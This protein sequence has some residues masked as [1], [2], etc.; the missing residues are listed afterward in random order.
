MEAAR[1]R[2]RRRRTRRGTVDSPLNVRLVRVASLLVVPALLAM[3]FSISTTGTL[4]R[5]ALAPL[6]DA[7]AAATLATQLQTEYPSRIP[8][9]PGDAGAARWF[10]E[11]ISASGFATR[12]DV[13]RESVPGLGDVVLRNVITTIPGRSAQAVILVAHR[14]NQGAGAPFGENASGTAALIELARGYAPQEASAAAQ[15]QRTVILVSTDA[16]AY[17]GAGAYRFVGRSQAARDAFAAVILDGI[18][19]RG[20]PQVLVA[21]DGATSPAPALVSTAVARVREQVGTTPEL[22]SAATQL[23]DLGIPYAA[24]EQGP[25]LGAGTAAVTL[26]TDRHGDAVGISTTRLG[27]LG[28]ATET[29]LG[30]IDAS[31]GRAFGTHDSLF[32]RGRKASGWTVRLALVVAVVPFALGVL[33]LVV[34]VR[35]RGLRIAP[36]ARSLRARVLF[37]LYA[38]LL[39]G[40]GAVLGV[41]PTGAA[42]PLPPTSPA[43]GGRPVAGLALLGIALLLGWLVG[44]RRLIVS[45]RATPEDRL[46]GYAVALAWLAA[47][48]VVTA[49][50]HPYTLLFV[51]PSLY[52]WLWL[53]LRTRIWARALVYGAGFAGLAFALVVLSREIGLSLPATA[54]YAA[55][56]V[57]VG[58]IPVS[59]ALL[60][61][62][63]LAAAAQ[64]AAL[65]F[66]RYTPYAG[67][68][69]PPPPSVVR[70]SV[71]AVVRR[72]RARA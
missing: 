48:A 61:I 69:E 42:L 14:D 60:V 20:S 3:L 2:G 18:A 39:L 41:F 65:A 38:G 40:I 33:D 51:L 29:L 68:T 4:P 44:R 71:G 23:V 5:P 12:E 52:T 17:G 70:E 53:P 45:S 28:S 37:W 36:A 10:E 27:Q 1:P 47:V 9:S 49:V 63:W 26:T 59:V 31:V 66:G 54:L 25:F 43:V 22:A 62:G 30:S 8:G 19:G 11:T 35:R 58:Y 6:F 50:T 57:T 13:W 21:G 7:Q 67:G 24:G 72:V 32:F 64:L 55:D 15:P 34:R 16:G 46:A 56:L